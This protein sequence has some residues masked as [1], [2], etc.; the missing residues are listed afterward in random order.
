M[1]AAHLVVLAITCLFAAA[2]NWFLLARGSTAP[3]AA[4]AVTLA[5]FAGGL[6]LSAGVAAIDQRGEFREEVVQLVRE[7]AASGMSVPELASASRLSERDVA[8]ILGV[9][10]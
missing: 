3:A 4:F 1:K 6:L 7:G 9:T 8:R 5:I 10:A 2:G